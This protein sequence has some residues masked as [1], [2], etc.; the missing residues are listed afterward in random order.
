MQWILAGCER[1]DSLIVNPHKWLFTPLDCSVFYTRKPDVVKA[2]FSLVPEFLS[3]AESLGD[4]VPN[5]MDYGIA[6][7]RRFR[8]LKLWMVM[9]YFGQEGIAARIREHNRLAHQ[10]S[11]WVQE[12]PD[13]DLLAPTPFSLVCLRAHP[14]D[15]HDESQLNALNE[16]ILNQINADGRFFLSHT[17]LHDKYTIRVA[18]GN[19]KTTE[20][21][22]RDLWTQL[23]K[24]TTR[25]NG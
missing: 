4:E 13:F 16:H 23:Q 12:S 8:A 25:M 6:L 20:Q 19:L 3:N 7:G 21:D 11:T 5:L 24:L 17:K 15:L 2:A 22:I 10:L 1:A 14:R 9:R 18:I